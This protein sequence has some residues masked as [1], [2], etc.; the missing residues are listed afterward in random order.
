MYTDN[1]K[2]PLEDI[3][4][5]Q[6]QALPHD[7]SIPT[8]QI[9]T[10]EIAPTYNVFT[11][12]PQPPRPSQPPQNQFQPPQNQFQ[13]YQ[14]PQP[15]VQQ[16]IQ[17]INSEQPV[18]MNCPYCQN[19]INTVVSRKAGTLTWIICIVCLVTGFF[20]LI[21]WCL[22]WIPFVIPACLDVEHTCPSCNRIVGRLN[23]M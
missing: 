12:S 19:Y 23:R 20:L 11:I 4:L 8:Q 7:T 22:C 10:A 5:G 9:P 6:G 16:S 14:K 13:P 18:G 2:A 3:P 17:T 21:P 15:P 1:S